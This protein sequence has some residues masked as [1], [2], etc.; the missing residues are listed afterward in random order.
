[1]KR[2]FSR[3][4][5]L[6]IAI[7]LYAWS[8]IARLIIEAVMGTL[9]VNP[10]QEFEQR[11]GRQALTL[12]V[13]SLA[14][15]PISTIFKWTEP[16]KRRRT[17]GLYAFMYAVIHAIIFVD[18]DYGLAWSL[19]AKTILQK[20]YILVGMLSFLL[21]TPLAFTSFDIWKRRL[22]KN[23]KRLHQLVYF[24]APLVILHY[25][26]SK[27]GNI[28]LLQGDIVRPFVYGLIIAVFLIFRIPAIRKSLASFSPRQL[29]LLLKRNQHPKA[30]TP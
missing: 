18:L 8:T 14:C 26:W 7:H 21:L 19:I 20:P 25:A 10:I 15:T 17:L 4:S 29:T 28:F 6:Q 30:D 11:T 9:S 16:I 13:L 1:M 27:K 22:G 5:P 12:L 24:I 3:Y 2:F 23:W